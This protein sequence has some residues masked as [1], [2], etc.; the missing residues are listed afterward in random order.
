MNLRYKDPNEYLMNGKSNE[1]I[2]DFWAAKPYTPEGVKSASESF[3]EIEDELLKPRIT[4]PPYMQK[5]ARN[6]GWRGLFKGE[7]QTLLVLQALVRA[8]M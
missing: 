5:N 1:F 2:S 8:L 7:Q 6:D 3:D 4:L